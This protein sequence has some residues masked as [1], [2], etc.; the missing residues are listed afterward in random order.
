VGEALVVRSAT[1]DDAPSIQAIYAPVVLRSAVSFEETPPGVDEV[2][3]RMLA[4][5]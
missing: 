3:A 5:P 1:A 2:V 4:E